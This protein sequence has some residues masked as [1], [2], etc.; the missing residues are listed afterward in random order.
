MDTEKTE[1]E[2]KTIH[3]TAQGIVQKLAVAPAGRCELIQTN[4]I[5][6]TIIG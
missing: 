5:T 4:T 1:K 2:E 3:E 6:T